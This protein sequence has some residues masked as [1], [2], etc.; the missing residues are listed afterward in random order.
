MALCGRWRLWLPQVGVA[1]PTRQKIPQD[2]RSKRSACFSAMV[3]G[4]GSLLAARRYCTICTAT[5][6]FHGVLRCIWEYAFGCGSRYLCCN[7]DM[8]TIYPARGHKRYTWPRARRTK[9]NG[10]YGSALGE[11]LFLWRNS[12]LI[13][14]SCERSTVC[15]WYCSRKYDELWCK[16]KLKFCC[17]AV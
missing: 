13:Q 14:D 8:P 6:L 11:N 17:V 4:D 12:F 5:L 1:A 16:L 15:V 3:K 9:W 10:K 2:A 7:S